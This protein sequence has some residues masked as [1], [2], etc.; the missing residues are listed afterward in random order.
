MK[1]YPDNLR[2]SDVRELVRDELNQRD[3]LISRIQFRESIQKEVLDHLKI[4]YKEIEILRAKMIE[5]E[6][7]WEAYHS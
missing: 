3:K 2:P 7:K 6:N 1:S 5:L 4:A